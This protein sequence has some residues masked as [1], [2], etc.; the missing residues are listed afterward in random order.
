MADSAAT[1]VLADEATSPPRLELRRASKVSL[2]IL[3]TVLILFARRPDQFLHPTLW[4]E[5]TVILREYVNHGWWSLLEPLNGYY[6]LISKIIAF[7]AFKTS[8]Y[9]A[10]QIE[11][12]L[13]VA[14]TCAVIVSV[15]LSP[16]HLQWPLLCALAVLIVP[17]DPEVFVVSVYAFWW[18]GILLL[19]A[20]FW[21]S[22]ARLQWLRWLYIVIGGL[23][24]PIIV[25]VAGLLAVRAVFERKPSE[26]F[27]AGLG[28]PVSLIQF[29]TIHGSVPL[30]TMKF[31]LGPFALTIQRFFGLFF[32]P[33]IGSLSSCVGFAVLFSLVFIAW[34]CRARLNGYFFLLVL[35]D[36]GICALTLLRIP[37]DVIHPFFAG[38]RYFF[39]PFILLNWIMIWL[40]SVSNSKTRFGFALALLI[41]LIMCA[42]HFARW[43]EPIDWQTAVSACDRSTQYELP[44]H[45]DGQSSTM[46]HA[47]MTGQECQKLLRESL[48]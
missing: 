42:P 34:S 15:A 9:W 32:I 23:S 46:W 37:V 39:Y 25:V 35:A 45:F 8:F 21:R 13:I 16:T 38:P 44:A 41:A 33:K 24:S 18:A 5:D 48:F 28:V 20:L 19:L 14:F 31:G 17:T 47:S 1:T 4:V 10:P 26:Y 22:D 43:H 7:I 6:V 40:A 12:F 11:L 30:N 2:L 29:V 36:T 3:A 27:A